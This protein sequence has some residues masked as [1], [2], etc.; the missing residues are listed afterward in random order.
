MPTYIY[1][2]GGAVISDC[3]SKANLSVIKKTMKAADI[4]AANATL[5]A[6]G[7]ITAADVIRAITV[8]PKFIALFTAIDVR[9]AGT[10]GNTINVGIAGGDEFQD[11]VDIVTIAVV[12]TVLG[13]DYGSAVLFPKVFTATDTIDVTYVADEI[14]GEFDLYV[15][16]IDLNSVASQQ[17]PAAVTAA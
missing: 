11:G 8:P 9:V 16:G 15:F 12:A 6:A 3:L 5:L 7:K 1:T 2:E 14:V 13:D 10:A 4:I 17:N